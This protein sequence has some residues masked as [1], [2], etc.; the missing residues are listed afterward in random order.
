MCRKGGWLAA[1]ASAG[2]L[3]A[4]GV[5]HCLLLLGYAKL[6]DCTSAAGKAKK[7]SWRSSFGL[8]VVPKLALR[9]GAALVWPV[10]TGV[11]GDLDRKGKDWGLGWA[12]GCRRVRG[13]AGEA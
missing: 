2:L 1:A 9:L 5:A 11:E 13:V 12:E 10:L 3:S 8:V 7:G 4:I 6:C